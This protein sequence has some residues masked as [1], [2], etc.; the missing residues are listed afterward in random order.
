M[1]KKPLVK[2]VV[3]RL[4]KLYDRAILEPHG[5]LF[6]DFAKKKCHPSMF[7]ETLMNGL[8]LT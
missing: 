2:N 4:V 5:F 6:I 8:S 1:N 7:G 3:E